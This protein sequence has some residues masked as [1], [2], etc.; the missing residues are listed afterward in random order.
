VLYSVHFLRFI[1]A[2]GVALHH[3]GLPVFIGGSGIGAAGV[4]M[5]F[6]ISGVVIGTSTRADAT[7]PEFA[8]KRL[9]RVAPLYWL[10]TLLALLW[11]Y[12]FTG[13]PTVE[14]IARSF[15]LWPDLQ[16]NWLPAYF[17]AWTLVFELWFYAAF[18]VCLLAGRFAKAACAVVV[19]LAAVH[20]EDRQAVSVFPQSSMIA[21]EFVFGLFIAVAIERKLM[22]PRWLG[23]LLL[24]ASFTWFAYYFNRP[25]QR[26]WSWGV[27]S[28]LL[29]YGIL[30]FDGAAFFKT[31]IA[32]LG[33]HAS[34][35]IYLFHMLIIDAIAVAFF[36]RGERSIDYPLLVLIAATTLAILV[37]VIIYIVAE[38][39]VLALLRR[40][41][42]PK[43]TILARPSPEPSSSP[44]API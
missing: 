17:P 36:M 33:G 23:A 39:P 4:D 25:G 43:K 24:V 38:K 35:G 28:G 22:P 2:T 19:V 41:L 9:I 37:S 10:A 40:L 27:P 32:Q 29:I 8:L 7:I 42:L 31:K 5:F 14:H 3:A 6:V 44:Q 1:A 12:R 34:Y 18:A 20:F 26:W 15:F 21:I 11:S 16:T 30:G 13:P